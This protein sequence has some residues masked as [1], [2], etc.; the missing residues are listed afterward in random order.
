MPK[1]KIIA[2]SWPGLSPEYFW[3]SAMELTVYLLE[4]RRV[5]ATQMGEQKISPPS[6]NKGNWGKNY[7]SYVAKT[8]S[9]SVTVDFLIQ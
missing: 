1:M 6:Q 8:I 4:K 3:L 9:F 5:E 2:I 7:L